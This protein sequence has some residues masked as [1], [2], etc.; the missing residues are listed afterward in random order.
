V[1]EGHRAHWALFIRRKD[2][3]QLGKIIHVVGAPQFGYKQEFKRNY[4]LT[5]TGRKKL[6]YELGKIPETWVKEGVPSDT[7]N[8]IPQDDLEKKAMDIKAPKA[9]GNEDNPLESDNCQWWLREYVKLLIQEGILN[10]NAIA[11]LD[12]AHAEEESRRQKLIANGGV[13]PVDE[14]ESSK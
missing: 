10:Q 9:C 6:I 12:Q 8:G 5:D 11:V 14:E 4:D 3:K 1:M 2:S 7:I 13:E